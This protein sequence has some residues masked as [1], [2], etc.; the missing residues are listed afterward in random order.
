M[1]LITQIR[2]NQA[3]A[4]GELRVSLEDD[5]AVEIEERERMTAMMNESQASMQYREPVV[6]RDNG[7][8]NRRDEFGNPM[9]RMW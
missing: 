8:G 2:I 4:S 9:G 3:W 7:M 5:M 1:D 6:G